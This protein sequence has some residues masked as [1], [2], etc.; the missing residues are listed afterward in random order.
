MSFSTS[1][2]AKP[3]ASV[4][5]VTD[6]AESSGNTS[7]GMREVSS[8]PTP[9]S[10]TKARTTSQGCRREL[11]MVA[12]NMFAAPSVTVG[13]DGAHQGGEVDVVAAAGHDSLTRFHA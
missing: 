12:S 1:S 6:G 5:T 10:T 7:S 3:L 13:L 9:T 4:T 11:R 2:G 8:K